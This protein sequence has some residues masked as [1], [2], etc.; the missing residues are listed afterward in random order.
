MR[1]KTVA[2]MMT[3]CG[4]QT[5]F[6]AFLQHG[7]DG[8]L[9]GFLQKI[10][11]NISSRVLLSDKSYVFFDWISINGSVLTTEKLNFLVGFRCSKAQNIKCSMIENLF[12]QKLPKNQSSIWPN[13][14]SLTGLYY[15]CI[16]WIS[17]NFV[18]NFKQFQKDYK[19]LID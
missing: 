13:C 15:T 2:M 8:F 11:V 17:S 5:R 10:C 14:R 1:R 6:L 19:Y 18:G 12:F 4:V 9:W 3:I 7:F 16:F